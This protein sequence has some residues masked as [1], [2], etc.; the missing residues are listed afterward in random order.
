MIGIKRI[1]PLVGYSGCSL[2]LCWHKAGYFVRKYSKSRDFNPR[3]MK[4]MEKQEYLFQ[5]NKR[6]EYWV[7]RILRTG[8]ERGLFFFDMEYIAGENVFHYAQHRSYADIDRIMKNIF[9]I[10]VDFSHE[11][12]SSRSNIY[13]GTRQKVEAILASVKLGSRIQEKILA[14]IKLLA[15][16]EFPKSLCHGDFTLENIIVGRNGALYLIDMLDSYYDSYW[17]DL[18]KLHQDFEM[19]GSLTSVFG[20]NKPLSKIKF[21]CEKLTTFCAEFSPD[22]LKVHHLVMML[23]FLRILPYAKNKGKFNRILERVLF[24]IEHI[25]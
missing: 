8:N 3:L 25:R 9:N 5:R 18:G 17:F 15:H 21:M 12:G 2:F 10:V 14:K 22:Y 19:N 1:T 4:Q 16:V 23:V 13:E 24:H 11:K 6:S 20:L 7:P